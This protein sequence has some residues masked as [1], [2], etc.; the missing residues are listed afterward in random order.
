LPIISD[1]SPKP[2]LEIDGD[3]VLTGLLPNVRMANDGWV[4]FGRE[5]KSEV[6]QGRDRT[7]IWLKLLVIAVLTIVPWFIIYEGVTA[8]ISLVR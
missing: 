1:P 2:P 8:L 7:Q 4:T 3:E 5:G 6:H